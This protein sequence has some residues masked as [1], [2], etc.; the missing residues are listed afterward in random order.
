MER[1]IL[2][3][4]KKCGTQRPAVMKDPVIG[5]YVQCPSCDERGSARKTKHLAAD[6]WNLNHGRRR[7]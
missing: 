6:D 3:P 1:I 5:Y 7:G 4:C 2:L